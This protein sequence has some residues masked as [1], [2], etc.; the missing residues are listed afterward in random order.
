MKINPYLTFAGDCAEAF[1]LYEKVLGGRLLASMPYAGTP[2]CDHVPA[3]WQDKVMHTAL[4]VGEV[5]IMGS[6]APPQMRQ[7]P[8][9]ISV[10]I[11]VETPQEAERVFAGLSQGATIHMPLA[12]TFWAKSFG[13][14]TDRFGTPWMVNS[15][16]E[17]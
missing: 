15:K 12:E 6:D 13:M 11:N 7:T 3:D 2:A 16:E 17:G 8:A 1:Q 9:G 14:L 4:Q 5:M 10:S